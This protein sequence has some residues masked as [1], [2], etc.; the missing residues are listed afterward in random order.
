M[1]FLTQFVAPNLNRHPFSQCPHK[2]IPLYFIHPFHSALSLL[3][4]NSLL[5]CY[6]FFPGF[7]LHSHIYKFKL[8]LVRIEDSWF[9]RGPNLTTIHRAASNRIT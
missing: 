2:H 4:S 7:S 6:F 9:N 8:F 3:S 1:I 5:V